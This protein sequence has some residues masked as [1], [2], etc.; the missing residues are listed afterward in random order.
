MTTRPFGAPMMEPIRSPQVTGMSHQPSSQARM[1][2]VAQV[3]VNSAECG[4]RAARHGAQ[5]VA[6]H[7]GG[8]GEDGEVRQA[9]S[10][11]QVV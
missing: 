8:V 10:G 2:R 9:S 1:P 11:L 4:Q 3:S 5:R 6:D 7:V